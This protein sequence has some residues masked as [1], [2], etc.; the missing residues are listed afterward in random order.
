MR[1]EKALYEPVDIFQIVRHTVCAEQNRV[2]L[3][4]L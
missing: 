1:L 3:A 2:A 4:L